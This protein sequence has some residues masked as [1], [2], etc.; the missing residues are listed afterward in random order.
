M[1]CKV[2]GPDWLNALLL[3]LNIQAA[4]S[5]RECLYCPQLGPGGPCKQLIMEYVKC[6]SIFARIFSYSYV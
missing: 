1:W 4:G 2:V 5:R 3:L 6:Y